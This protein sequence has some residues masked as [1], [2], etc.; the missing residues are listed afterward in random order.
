VAAGPAKEDLS[1]HVDGGMKLTE[2]SVA[3]L[4]VWALS[5]LPAAAIDLPAGGPPA[6][7]YYVPL[8]LFVMTV[9][10][11][12]IHSRIKQCLSFSLFD[13]FNSLC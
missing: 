4:T 8:G 6:G 7:S 13:Y 2:A 5:A 3:S 9:P 11:K 1:A 10:G 12:R